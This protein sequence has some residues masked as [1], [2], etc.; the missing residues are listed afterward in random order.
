MDAAQ[1]NVALRETLEA[2]GRADRDFAALLLVAAIVASLG[3]EQNSPATIIGAMVVA[4]MMLP[5]RALGYALLQFDRRLIWHAARTILGS[6]AAILVIG[7][8]VGWVSRRPEFGSEILSRTSVTFL[9]LCVAIAA[10]TLAGLSRALNHSKITDA[11]VGVGI[12]V[13]LVPPLCAAGI[14]MA[15]GAWFES[16]GALA[17]FVTNLVGISLACA[18]VFACTGYAPQR[19]WNAVAGFAVFACAV[20]AI[21]PVLGEA[22]YRARQVSAIEHFLATHSS[23]FAPSVLAVESTTVSWKAEPYALLVLVRA[24]RVPTGEEVRRLNDAID[25][26]TGQHYAVTVVADPAITV[27]PSR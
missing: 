11:L 6:V 26:E 10:G 21:S 7:A 17:I 8:I 23:R 22:G 13:S 2:D 9:G 27:T 18:V 1:A 19:R 14:T 24:P 4:P 12:S 20:A 5:I 25:R 16:A 3:L 15:Y